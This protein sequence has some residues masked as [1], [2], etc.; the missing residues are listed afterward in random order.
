MTASGNG[1]GT[2]FS[3]NTVSVNAFGA[4]SRP[5]IVSTRRVLAS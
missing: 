4:V 3:W 5:S 2:P 1:I